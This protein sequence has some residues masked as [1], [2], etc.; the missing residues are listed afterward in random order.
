MRVI[1]FIA[2]YNF[3]TG[4]GSTTELDCKARALLARGHEVSVVTVFSGQNQSFSVPYPVHEELIVSHRLLG[5]QKGIYKLLKKYEDKTDVFHVE[6]HFSYGS[7]WYRLF[8]GG[9]AKPVFVH[10]NRELSS[11]PESRQ[12]E[13]VTLTLKQKARNIKQKARYA[14]EKFF[15]AR[16]IN[17]N[18]WFSFTSPYLLEVYANFGLERSRSQVVPDFFDVM[19]LRDK[20]ARD[21]MAPS[22]RRAEKT[23]WHLFSSGRM[24]KE[25]GFDVLIKAVACL[26][27]SI[28]YE[29]TISGDGPERQN[30]EVMARELGVYEKVKF[31][32]WTERDELCRL[33][34]EADLFIIPRWRPELTSMLALEA[35]AFQLPYLVTKNTAI[36]WQ[37]GESALTFNDE[38]PADCAKAIQLALADGALRERLA[39]TSGSR[40]LDLDCSR[41]V[42]ALEA[43]LVNLTKTRTVKL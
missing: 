16:L 26:P 41:L 28:N 21:R 22:A 12:S 25:K 10:F 27:K 3:L 19:A 40:A 33:F 34:K 38:D 43:S 5:I 8:R 6:G 37:A 4:G 31:L 29:L 2:K 1:F 7:G 24:V 17:C 23:L 14:L 32:G 11:F 36:S 39:A 13:T 9:L 42:G 20:E 35:M 30:L 18:A 15:G